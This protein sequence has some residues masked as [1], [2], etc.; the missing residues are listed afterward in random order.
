MKTIE[1][2]IKEV[3]TL[4]SEL[5]GELLKA[6]EPR[7]PREHWS[8]FE[9]DGRYH[10]SSSDHEDLKSRLYMKPG[11]TLAL[12]RE[13]LPDAL[14]FERWTNNGCSVLTGRGELVARTYFPDIAAAMVKEH[15]ATIDRLERGA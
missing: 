6:K 3:E 8:L 15:N 9:A 14:K 10:S 2:K 1:D 7:V 11:R 4:L 13:V 12:F 5:K